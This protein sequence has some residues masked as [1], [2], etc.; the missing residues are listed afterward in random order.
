MQRKTSLH[1]WRKTSP[2]QAKDPV[3]I[4][5][6][7]IYSSPSCKPGHCC[8]GWISIKCSKGRK[9]KKQSAG[10]LTF[11][12]LSA[13][14]QY[15]VAQYGWAFTLSRKKYALFLTVHNSRLND[16]IGN[17]GSVAWSNPEF[18]R[19]WS[20]SMLSSQACLSQYAEWIS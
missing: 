14:F 18:S 19:V 15:L 16:Q 10:H 9:E 7:R 8:N 6:V 1:K 13:Q 4:A 3:T 17:A 5:T 20:G 12:C 11:P 2:V